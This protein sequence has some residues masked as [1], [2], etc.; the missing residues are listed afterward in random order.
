MPNQP[1]R[2]TRGRG[3]WPIEPSFHGPDVGD[4]SGPEPVGPSDRELAI[5][6]VR[7]RGPPVIRLGRR[8]PLFHSVGPEAFGA[9]QAGYAPL[10]DPMPARQEGLPDPATDVDLTALPVDQADARRI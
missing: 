8:S 7:R 2:A 6:P 10:A 4:V 1:R 3:P 9:H 5:E